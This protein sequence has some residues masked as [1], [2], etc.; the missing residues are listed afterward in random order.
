MRWR[1]ALGVS[2]LL[3]LLGAGTGPVRAASYT[4]GYTFSRRRATSAPVAQ[5]GPPAPAPAG[6]A[7][8][9]FVVP[10]PGRSQSTPVVVGGTWYQWTY[11]DRG[12]RGALWSGRLDAAAG[13]SS[14]GVRLRLPGQAHR[15]V[16]AAPGERLDEPSDAAVSPD[17]RWVA[18]GAGEELYW[19]PAGDPAAGAVALITGEPRSV[20]AANSTSP[21]FVPDPAVASGWEVCDGNWDGGFACFA[22]RRGDGAAPS[23][24]VGYLASW[25]TPADGDG[26]TAITSSASY[27]GPLHDL[28]FGVASAHEPRVMALDPRSGSF[29]A[30]D[31]GGAVRA[32]VWAAV[33]I[34]GTH[35][36][37]TDAQGSAYAFDARTGALTH[38]RLMTDAGTDIV[39]PAVGTRHLYLLVHR[40]G[41]ILRLR[42]PSLALPASAPARLGGAAQASALTVVHAAGVPSEVFYATTAGGVH[43][44]ASGARGLHTLGAWS[45]APSGGSYN[46]TAAVVEGSLVLLWSDGA[47]AAWA[48]AV[49]RPPM[50]AAP[51]GVGA[52]SGGLQIYHLRPRLTALVTP[53]VGG[54]GA[55]AQLDVLAPPGA[56]VSA[57]G[58]PWGPLTLQGVSAGAILCPAALRAAAGGNFGV[59]PQAGAR[60]VAPAAGCGPWSQR[61]GAWGALA[62]AQ[63]G[64]AHPAFAGLPPAAWQAAGAGYAAWTATLPV[65]DAVGVYPLGVTVRVSGGGTAHA[66]VW[67]RAACASG[68]A[69]G[70][71]GRCT[72]TLQPQRDPWPAGGPT[73][74]PPPGDRCARDLAPGVSTL[75]PQEFSL[76]CQ[77][78]RGWLVNGAVTACYGTWWNYVRRRG[79]AGGCTLAP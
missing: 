63:G 49:P 56:A 8:E 5:E 39:S 42:R 75:T 4:W 52:V 31:G 67:L 14:A 18:F 60:T 11:W 65:P 70:V 12:R 55:S 72:L 33:A 66:R 79:A 71:G 47:A 43:V 51:V 27:G 48:Q 46:W 30:M 28:Y 20:V 45:G 22:V 24:T 61:A 77:P 6:P 40:Y 50:A 1:S 44:A 21:T 7:N 3:L 68:T 58:G 59:F 57:A 37:A 41:E 64:G 19:W 38:A 2:L 53:A 29:S 73:G 26:Y 35:V 78:L 16:H 15:T 69:A 62:A 36:Y 17:G 13:S 54:T 34:G 32:P 9:P 76:L 25:T 74:G 10:L 23:A